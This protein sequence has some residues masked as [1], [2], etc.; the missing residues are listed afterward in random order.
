MSR[1]LKICLVCAAWAVI[2]TQ[3]ALSF[4]PSWLALITGLILGCLGGYLTVDWRTVVW[5]I[6]IAWRRAT[7]W[8][9]DP[10]RLLKVT[11][12]IGLI[13]TVIALNAL[14]WVLL[15]S[16]VAHYNQNQHLQAARIILIPML[17]LTSFAIPCM[18]FNE[19]PWRDKKELRESPLGRLAEF[20]IV[21]FT[22]VALIMG[23]RAA[24][25][26]LGKAIRLLPS[27]IRSAVSVACITSR[28]TWHFYRLIHTEERWLC[29]V[30]IACGVTLGWWYSSPIV[31]GLAGGVF[32]LTNRLL[33]AGLLLRTLPVRVRS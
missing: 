33:I 1:T 8:R 24:I 30:D 32:W 15:L 16:I 6:P 23:G 22:F 19:G 31:G 13:A 21:V 18:V 28:F 10:I 12:V 17:T 20:N 2:G 29:A 26:L 27:G 4:S 11:P 5:A 14:P 7:S 3:V 9:P 25:K